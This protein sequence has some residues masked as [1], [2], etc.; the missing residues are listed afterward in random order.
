MFIIGVL[1]GVLMIAFGLLT[2]WLAVVFAMW[3]LGVII[4]AVFP[5]IIPTLIW[6]I[7]L[8]LLLAS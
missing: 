7:V 3:I 2:S 8:W 6:I 1:M 5:I 4:G